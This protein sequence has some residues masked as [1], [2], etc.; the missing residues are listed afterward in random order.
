MATLPESFPP[1]WVFVTS[2]GVYV[3]FRLLRFGSREKHLPPGPP[4]YPI[5]GNAHLVVDKDLYKRSERFSS[6]FLNGSTNELTCFPRFQDWGNQYGEVY[7][8]TIG[9]GT[10]IVLNSRRA[11]HDLVDKRSAIYSSRPQDEQFHRALKGENIANMDADAGWRSQ[12]KITARFFAP[13]KLDGDMARIA[14]AE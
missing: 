5:I 7:S 13:G 2:I 9:K 11:V 10:M 14:E 4:T 3:V 6:F 12:R 8:L 1:F